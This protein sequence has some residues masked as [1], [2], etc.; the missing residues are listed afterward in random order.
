MTIIYIYVDE[1]KAGLAFMLLFLVHPA[2]VLCCSH[3]FGE[4]VSTMK[5]EDGE[6]LHEDGAPQFGAFWHQGARSVLMNF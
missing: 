4:T 2:V 3:L 6:R 1:K 5:A